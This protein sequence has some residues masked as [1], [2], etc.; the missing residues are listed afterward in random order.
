MSS[1]LFILETETCVSVRTLRLHTCVLN[2]FRSV[3]HRTIEFDICR[4]ILTVTSKRC[5]RDENEKNKRKIRKKLFRILSH[6]FMIA[7]GKWKETFV[8]SLRGLQ[9]YVEACMEMT[10]VKCNNCVGELDREA[11][12]MEILSHVD[13]L[14]QPCKTMVQFYFSSLVPDEE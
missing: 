3:P 2:K 4:N 12:L 10:N 9:W 7:G 14:I 8:F 1:E 11:A 13:T 6:M 5:E